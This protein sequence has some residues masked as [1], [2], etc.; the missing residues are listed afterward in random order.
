MWPHWKVVIRQ[1]FWDAV[2]L[3]DKQI[4]ACGNEQ[5]GRIL[6]GARNTLLVDWFLQYPDAIRRGE[7]LCVRGRI[8]TM[9]V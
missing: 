5:G 4:A 6:R 8:G 3:L 1:G 2:D 9:R 7:R